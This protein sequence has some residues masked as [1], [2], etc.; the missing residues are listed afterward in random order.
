MYDLFQIVA[1]SSTIQPYKYAAVV[2][3]TTRKLVI[4][5]VDIST[6]TRELRNAVTITR[7]KQGVQIALAS[8]FK[9]MHS[10]YRKMP[11]NNIQ[12]FVM[13]ERLK[14][15]SNYFNTVVHKSGVHN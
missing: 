8:E 12:K 7:S 3:F 1:T 13:M 4:L 2:R 5:A 6:T 14:Y 15:Y 9:L 11:K 10:S